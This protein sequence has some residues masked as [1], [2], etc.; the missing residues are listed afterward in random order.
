MKNLT[1][2]QRANI[3]LKASKLVGLATVYSCH[4]IYMAKNNLR[5]YK[6]FPIGSFYNFF[7]LEE[8]PEFKL[9]EP[10]DEDLD[11]FPESSNTIWFYYEDEPE[12]ETNER[13]IALLLAHEIAL[14]P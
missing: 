8:F 2:K 3:Y 6:K 9:F 14:N 7:N 10:S 1:N 13:I 4:A 12:K 5:S 11:N